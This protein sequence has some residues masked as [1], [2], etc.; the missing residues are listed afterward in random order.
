MKVCSSAAILWY[1]KLMQQVSLAE[2]RKKRTSTYPPVGCSQLYTPK[3]TWP[4]EEQCF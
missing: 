4:D 2:A 1:V 3:C